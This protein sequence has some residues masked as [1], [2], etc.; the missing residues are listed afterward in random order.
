[1]CPSLMVSALMLSFAVRCCMLEHVVDTSFLDQFGA[2]VILIRHSCSH[3]PCVST[4]DVCQVP[5]LESY[6]PPEQSL[7]GDIVFVLDDG[8]LFSAHSLYVQHASQTLSGM[9]SDLTRQPADFAEETASPQ[10]AHCAKRAKQQLRLPLKEVT[11]RQMLLLLQLLYS[12]TREK[13]LSSLA[14]A[15]LVELARV[16]HRYAFHFAL[17]LV[18]SRLVSICRGQEGLDRDGSDRKLG[19]WLT[20][21][22]APGQLE[23]AAALHLTE[24]EQYVAAFLGEHAHAV[25]LSR[26]DARAAAMLRG[27]RKLKASNI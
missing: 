27:A 2:H 12:L 26:L 18:D 17:E 19:I 7:S 3:A 6:G 10:D 24:Y 11:R 1:M 21:R 22:D 16:A 9:I 8:T 5:E 23:L 15:D 20:V 4:F 13:W 14:V 25:D